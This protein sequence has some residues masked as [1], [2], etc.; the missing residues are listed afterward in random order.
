MNLRAPL[1]ASSQRR[2][3][4]TRRMQFIF[5]EWQARAGFERVYT[6]HHLRHTAITNVYRA[7]KDLFLAQRFAR[8]ANPI[9]TVIYTHP[10]DEELYE[11]I[12]GI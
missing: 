2:R 8:H 1:F 5:A 11:A 7:T 10:S 4:S 3:I 6:F 12:A 9:T